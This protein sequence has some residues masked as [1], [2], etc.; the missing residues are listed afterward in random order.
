MK[1]RVGLILVIFL[2]YLFKITTSCE[3]LIVGGTLGGVAA[4]IESAARGVNTCLVAEYCML[5]GQATIEGVVC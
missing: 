1:G 5:G 4:A 3:V 2:F